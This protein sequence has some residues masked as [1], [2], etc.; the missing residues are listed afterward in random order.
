MA[1]GF[2]H[3]VSA[4]KKHIQSRQGSGSVP[5]FPTKTVSNLRR[6]RSQGGR[7]GKFRQ[8]IRGCYPQLRDALSMPFPYLNG[9]SQKLGQLWSSWAVGLGEIST[10]AQNH[11]KWRLQGQYSL[12]F[13]V[14]S[15][16]GSPYAIPI[17][18]W[19]LS[20]RFTQLTSSNA[21]NSPVRHNFIPIL[22]KTKPKAKVIT[23]SESA[24]IGFNIQHLDFK[25]DA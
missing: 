16:D 10:P 3:T 13:K 23:P 7:K 11:P 19:V 5:I 20:R 12:I 21:T 24:R 17:F 15:L 14:L 9:L 22:E 1:G 25:L 8:I 4:F 18:Y 6:R 2:Y